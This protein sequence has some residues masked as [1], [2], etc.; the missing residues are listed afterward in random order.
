MELDDLS[1][2]LYQRNRPQKEKKNN[3]NN[4]KILKKSKFIQ[5]LTLFIFV[6]NQRYLGIPQV[7]LLTNYTI[8]GNSP[9]SA[10]QVIS[11]TWGVPRYSVVSEKHYLG[12]SQV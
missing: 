6:E 12:S 1:S 11:T 10:Y 5:N 9:G 3:K 7:V 2:Q 8:P 4:I